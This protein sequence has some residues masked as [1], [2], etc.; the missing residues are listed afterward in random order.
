MCDQGRLQFIEKPFLEVQFAECLHLALSTRQPIEFRS[1]FHIVKSMCSFTRPEWTK[2]FAKP[3]AHAPKGQT[4]RAYTMPTNRDRHCADRR[5]PN[6]ERHQSK[7]SFVIVQWK[8]GAA[9]RPAQRLSGGL[10]SIWS[11]G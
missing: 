8:K 1:H 6:V 3:T 9:P 11:I 10:V 7:M 2:E 4:V 5:E